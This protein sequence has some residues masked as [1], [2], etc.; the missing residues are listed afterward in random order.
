MPLT[1]G[2]SGTEGRQLP[3]LLFIGCLLT[4]QTLGQGLGVGVSLSSLTTTLQKAKFISQGHTF[5]QWEKWN[6]NRSIRFQ[7]LFSTWKDC[8]P[9]WYWIRSPQLPRPAEQW[10][11]GTL[12]TKAGW[13]WMAGWVRRLKKKN[14]SGETPELKVRGQGHSETGELG[15]EIV[16]TGQMV[17]MEAVFKYLKGHKEER[18]IMHFVFQE[19]ADWEFLLWYSGN[20]SN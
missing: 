17:R 1:C 16:A 6:Q 20:E 7:N 19:K 9:T 5:T 11:R 13:G 3:Q 14:K 8:I 10:L 15:Q 4:C 2:M 18:T 12:G